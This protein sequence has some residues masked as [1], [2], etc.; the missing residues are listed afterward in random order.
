MK[1]EKGE[2]NPTQETLKN[3]PNNK[4]KKK[5]IWNK[6]KTQPTPNIAE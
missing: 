3:P 5:L 1:N 4:T 6:T 2:K